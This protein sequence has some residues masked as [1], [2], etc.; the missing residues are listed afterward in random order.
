M[1]DEIISALPQDNIPLTE[2]MVHELLEGLIKNDEIDRAIFL[3]RDLRATKMSLRI[4]TFN[5]MIA[6]CVEN[7]EPEEAFQILL[8][9]KD[10][11]G[12]HA[13]TERNWWKVLEAAAKENQ[14]W[15]ELYNAYAVN[16]NT[17]LLG[18]H[19]EYP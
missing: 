7:N 8:A 16:G 11:H 19:T 17:T 9:L 5:L 6:T 1:Q 2:P 15:P 10:S 3:F 18:A 4:R 12:E 14:V 13:I